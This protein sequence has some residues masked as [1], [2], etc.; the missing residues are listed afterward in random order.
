MTLVR[1]SKAING[2]VPGGGSSGFLPSARRTLVYP[3]GEAG[4]R[5]REMVDVRCAHLDISKD[6]RVFGPAPILRSVEG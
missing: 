2:G 5:D 4:G 1:A 3:P 6:A